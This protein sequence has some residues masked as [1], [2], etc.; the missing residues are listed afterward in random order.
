MPSVV[1]AT[2]RIYTTFPIPKGITLR[3]PH[4]VSNSNPG[5]QKAWSWSVWRNT[6]TYWDNKGKEHEI[7]GNEQEGVEQNPDDTEIDDGENWGYESSDSEEADT[8]EEDT[9]DMMSAVTRG[10]R[11]CGATQDNAVKAIDALREMCKANPSLIE[12]TKKSE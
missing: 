11:E 2:T 3:D 4:K 7:K 5:P 12:V 1:V 9:E 8:Q 10:A 6:L